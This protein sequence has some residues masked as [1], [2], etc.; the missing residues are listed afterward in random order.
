MNEQR[1]LKLAVEELK[2]GMESH[3][4]FVWFASCISGILRIIIVILMSC[5]IYLLG[6]LNVSL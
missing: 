1:E 3:H 6:D 4:T 2:E 5:I